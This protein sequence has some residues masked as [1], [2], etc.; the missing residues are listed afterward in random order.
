M[1]IRILLAVILLFHFFCVLGQED[2]FIPI[3]KQGC[4]IIKHRNYNLCYSEQFEQALWV[5]YELTSEETMGTVN[6]TDNFRVDP[7]ISTGSSTLKDYQGSGYDRGHL[8]PAG[9]MGFDHE[10]MSESFYMS[11]MSPQLPGFNRGIW[12][13]LESLVRQWADVNG[14]IHV[15]TGGI[16]S[17]TDPTIGSN[18]VCVPSK[19]YKVIYAPASHE[20]IAFIL[21]NKKSSANLKDYAIRVDDVEIFTGIDFFHELDD[22]LEDKLESTINSDSWDFD[23]KMNAGKKTSYASVQCKGTA[24]STGM[25]CT[26]NTINPSG[27]CHHHTNQ[28]K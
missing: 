17:S 16:P 7:L 4:Q 20:M 13:N 12:K 10:A 23:V 28:A 18:Q 21:E 2:H 27:F 25:Q 26:I 1:T 5:A 3:S 8:A 9:D 24:K 6:R 11:N 15:F 14:M 22:A 19:F